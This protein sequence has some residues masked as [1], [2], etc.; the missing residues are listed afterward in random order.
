MPAPSVR[1]EIMK[2]VLRILAWSLFLGLLSAVGWAVFAYVRHAPRCVIEGPL[3][4]ERLLGDGSQLLAKRLV[5]GG[6]T[7]RDSL[8]VWDLRSGAI[9]HELLADTAITEIV[10]S[11][12]RRHAAV[13]VEEAGYRFGSL[14]LVDFTTAE[15][16]RVNEVS[17]GTDEFSPPGRWWFTTTPH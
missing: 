11:P 7:R 1:R 4:V 14:R 9:V 12:D 8:T 2:F 16:W 10:M 5:V 17:I 13:W 3:T 6:D 15:E